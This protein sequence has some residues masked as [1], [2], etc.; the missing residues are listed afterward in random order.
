[1]KNEYDSLSG[2]ER[3]LE[4]ELESYSEDEEY[5]FEYEYDDEDG[6]EEYE[7][8]GGEDELEM[9]FESLMDDI[10]EDE[11]YEFEY[12][13]ELEDSIGQYA[14]RFHE[15][16]MQEFES[17]SS[18]DGQLNRLLDDMEREFFLGGL[19]KKAGK[20]A[21]NKIKKL[22][23]RAARF[24]KRKILNNRYLRQGMGFLKNRIPGMQAFR[25]LTQLARGNLRGMLG[26]LAKSALPSLVPGGAALMPILQGFGFNEADDPTANRDAWRNFAKVA[27]RSYEVLADN[28]D[29]EIHDPIHASQLA[30]RSLEQAMQENGISSRSKRRSRR[31]GSRRH[32]NLRLS[33]GE[34]LKISVDR[35]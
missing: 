22:G 31:G 2:L 27:A 33:P 21:G 12:E 17:E 13:F 6:E 23:G 34:E 20:W 8:Y 19:L 28:L 15:L 35:R 16:S 11:E 29:E 32:V 7:Y 24:A 14:D 3:E 26:T 10:D 9:E 5:E 4:M 18:L 1:M 25:G 30:A